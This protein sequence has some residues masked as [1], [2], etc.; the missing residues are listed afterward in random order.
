VRG[1]SRHH[2]RGLPKN[3]T[4]QWYERGEGP[5]RLAHDRSLI[6]AAYPTLSQRVVA[7]AGEVQLEGGLI[8]RAECGIPTEVAVRIEFPFDYPWSEPRAFDSVGR[9]EHSLDRHFSTETGRCCL[10]LPPK[11]QWDARNPDCLILFLDEVAVFFDRQL[12]YDA[13]GQVAWP[14]EQYGHGPD[15]YWEWILEE[16]GGSAELVVPFSPEFEG[17]FRLGRND[18][19]RCG[20]G[21]KYKRCHIVAIERIRREI[22]PSLLR[23]LFISHRTRPEAMVDAQPSFDSICCGSIVEPKPICGS[24][25]TN[26]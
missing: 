14:G 9:F 13:G 5:A 21:K 2:L 11:S 17:S 18:T 20:S 8:Y 4:K 23:A 1:R 6:A 12:I 10:W 19:C 15:G 25:A 26:T 7:D 24:T 16:F 22:A 3:K